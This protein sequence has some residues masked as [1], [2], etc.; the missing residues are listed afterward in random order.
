MPPFI[1]F[2]STSHHSPAQSAV[3]IKFIPLLVGYYKRLGWANLYRRHVPR[4]NGDSAFMATT[5]ALG[6]I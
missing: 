5:S 3:V 1:N 6:K 2:D 4:E